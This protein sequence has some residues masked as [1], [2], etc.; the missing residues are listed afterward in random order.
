MIGLVWKPVTTAQAI[1]ASVGFALL[2]YSIATGN[3]FYWLLNDANW[4]FHEFGHPFFGLLGEV[5][6]LYGGTLMELIVP[7]VCVAAF[8]RQGEPV[9]TAVAGVWFFENLFYIAWYMDTTRMDFPD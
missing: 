7:L 8:M 3:R 9:G 2:V 5:P 1:A 4:A 6:G